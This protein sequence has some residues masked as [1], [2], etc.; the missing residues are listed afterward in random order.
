MAGGKPLRQI[1]PTVAPMD[2]RTARPGPKLADPFYISKDWRALLAKIIH[3][4]GRR[5][6]QCGKTHEDDGSL[7]VVIGDHIVERRD[8]GAELDENNIRLLCR[9]AG[10]DGRPH[11]DGRRGGCHARKT[12]EAAKERMKS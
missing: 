8:G 6:E 12:A 7:V 3:K 4:R 11:P 10:G 1:G 5:C 2:M 9:A